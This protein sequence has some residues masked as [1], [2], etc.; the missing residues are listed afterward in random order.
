MV[1][2]FRTGFNG[3]NNVVS[4]ETGLC[5]E[6]AS[7]AKQSFAEEADINQIMYRFGVSGQLPQNVRMPTYDDFSEVNDFQS[8]MNALVSARESFDAMPANVRARFHNDPAEFV[9]FCSDVANRDEAR[10]MG[11]LVPQLQ[12]L[13]S[14]ASASVAGGGEAGRSSGAPGMISGDRLSEAGKAS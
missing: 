2:Y 1:P 9:E 14:P 7:L 5:C 13:A 6:D 4:D 12:E 10:K 8:A 11:L 3:D